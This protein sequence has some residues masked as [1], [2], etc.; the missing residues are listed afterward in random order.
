MFCFVIIVVDY[1]S[2][3]NSVRN[4]L[5]GGT[6]K[7]VISLSDKIGL[8]REVSCEEL[9]ITGKSTTIDSALCRL[10]RFHVDLPKPV[11]AFVVH[12]LVCADCRKILPELTKRSDQQ[13]KPCQHGKKGFRIGS[14]CY[15]LV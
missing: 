4:D 6:S 5:G 3:Y 8:V 9:R 10:E 14:G 13:T 12:L 2:S 11:V 15:H 1:T 7:G